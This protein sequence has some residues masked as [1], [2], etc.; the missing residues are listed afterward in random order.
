MSCLALFAS[1][2]MALSTQGFNPG[3]FQ[4]PPA[5]YRPAP[6]WF[7]NDAMEKDEIVSQLKALKDA[8][9]GGVMF[10]PRYG[11]G[12]EYGRAELGYY[13]STE[14][15]DLVGY[16]VQQC[17]KLGLEVWL[18]DDYNWPSGYGGGRVLLGG[19]VGDRTVPANPEFRA[20]HI[21]CERK[22]INGPREYYQE[23]PKGELVRVL[24]FQYERNIL[25]R[26]TKID[27]TDR[28]QDGHFR[29]DA[30]EGK[31]SILFLLVRDST[32]FPAG[33][34][35]LLYVDLMNRDCIAKFIDI[36]HQEY[37][38]R[39][40]DEFGKT[41][42]G[43]FT[44]EP[45]YFNN[46][47]WKEDPNTIPWTS[48]L[49]DTFKK[50]KGYDLVEALP[51][52]WYEIEGVSNRVR[53]DFWEVASHLYQQN[54]FKQMQDWCHQHNILSIGHVLEE[55][56]RFHR[57]F[58]G[59]DFYETMRYLDMVGIDQIGNRGFGRMNPKFGSSGRVLFG[60]NRVISET[61]GAYSWTLT[62]EDMREILNWQAVRG[63][64]LLCPHACYYSVKGPRKYDAPPDLFLHNFWKPY[65]HTYA[66]YCGRLSYIASRG[67]HVA[68]V[69]VLYPVSGIRDS[70]PPD[71][72][73]RL[74]DM[75]K[76][77]E[78]VSDVLL[79][80]QRDFNYIPESALIA[81][82][83]YGVK[84]DIK[85]KQLMVGNGRYSTVIVPPTDVLDLRAA[86]MLQ[87]FVR[88][89][90]KVIVVRDLPVRDPYLPAT[91]LPVFLKNTFGENARSSRES[92]IKQR[93]S[94]GAWIFSA[95]AKPDKSKYKV[96]PE[97]P[98]LRARYAEDW[99]SEFAHIVETHIPTGVKVDTF[100]PQLIYRHHRTGNAD[101]FLLVN[102]AREDLDRKVTFA[103][104]GVPLQADP[105]TGKVEPYRLY[106]NEDGKTTV[107]LHLK[108]YEA[109]VLVFKPDTK[110]PELCI[111]Q[112]NGQVLDINNDTVTQLV[113]ETGKAFVAGEYK[114]EPFKVS[115]DVTDQLEPVTIEGEF[116]FS[117]PGQQPYK[118]DPT[119]PWTD[120]H[121]RYSGWATYSK[122][123]NIDPSMLVEAR[124]LFLDL[125]VVNNMADVTI[126]SK[127]LG[128]MFWSPYRM[129]ITE[130]VK[131]GQNKLTVRVC[132]TWENQ[133]A[134]RPIPSGLL[135]QPKL[136]PMH[137]LQLK[138]K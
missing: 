78:Q 24:A 53:M 105:L 70:G 135:S 57:C 66:D 74:D 51:G 84:V 25:K 27:L 95:R 112:H 128:P 130:A 107:L 16:T 56:F 131:P 133:Y 122:D 134:N 10:H 81:K 125:G 86:L 89:G 60:K 136:V 62:F 6:F 110:A 38:K 61:Y 4:D 34:Q 50:L 123:F 58:E 30:P 102:E 97:I 54:F 68:D 117:I 92:I 124:R 47:I 52:M 36:T 44:D 91:E 101:V 33:K 88:S 73:K 22:N 76:K 115:V 82:N 55:N 106:K 13:F 29:W 69:A 9:V 126:N 116:D 28:A 118:R 75:Y 7:W 42:K 137:V 127:N 45:A 129:D 31:W 120:R 5:E 23:V 99:I 21:A 40:G 108:P 64:N 18:Y 20:R 121:P 65:F 35:D 32:H 114:G 93:P 59:G 96:R 77:F 3:H 67:S 26:E 1:S 12:G 111:H 48:V 138:V 87:L 132:N 83:D 103:I 98:R 19:V 85:D 119:K 39:F 71:M 11:L 109:T 15:F 104:D 49:F 37:Y 72:F 14:Y 46:N 79:E 8:G 100:T 113:S 90:G 43:I 17:K 63:V 80:H 2:V 41:I 94:G